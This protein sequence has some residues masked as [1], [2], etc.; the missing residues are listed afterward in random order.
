[1]CNNDLVD[2]KKSLNGF[3]V[4]RLDCMPSHS[5]ALR[6]SAKD[7]FLSSPLLLLRPFLAVRDSLSSETEVN[8]RDFI[9]L[10]KYLLVSLK[11]IRLFS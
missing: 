4:I 5:I 10:L 3:I 7:S 2:G 9:V 6:F 1:M 11:K 8:N